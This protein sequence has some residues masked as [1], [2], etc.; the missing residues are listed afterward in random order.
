MEVS[1]KPGKYIIAVSGGVDSMV[2]LDVLARI[3]YI[4]LV[5]A[6]LDHGIRTDSGEDRKL[7]QQVAQAHGLACEVMQVQLGPNASEDQA[8]AVRYEFLE[9][10]R[11]RHD[12]RAI[13]TAHHQDDVIE[14]MLI[15]LI[16][17]TNRHGLSSLRS[18]AEL[19]RPF[20]GYTKEQILDYARVH[21]VQWREDST[22]VSD[23]Y[24]RNYLRSHIVPRMLPRQRQK[25]LHIYSTM[26]DVND[27]IDYERT[28][29]LKAILTREGLT[30]S[31][32]IQ[33]PHALAKEVLAAWLSVNGVALRDRKQLER[34]VTAA[35]IAT[36]GTT[37]DIDKRTIMKVS[38]KFVQISP[39]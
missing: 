5:V 21:N 6:H 38:R 25:L 30:R 19:L 20:V 23:V 22:N 4:E 28:Q 39:R 10:V 34:L 2:L 1:L 7:V 27:Q 33:L 17:G 3:P 26:L 36:V 31:Q 8:R 32:F 11:A 24:L 35:K 14:T 9:Q 16:R 15:N 18:K 13:V 12:A 37:H 29:L